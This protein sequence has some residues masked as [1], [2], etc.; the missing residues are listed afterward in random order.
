MMVY[1]HKEIFSALHLHE[2]MKAVSPFRLVVNFREFQIGKR[3]PSGL[4]D[5]R[6]Y[7]LGRSEPRCRRIGGLAQELF[8]SV[9]FALMKRGANA[10]LHPGR[11][12]ENLSLQF[13]SSDR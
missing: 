7:S 6:L 8:H 2:T 1:L 4:S 9:L 3:A 10:R 5:G 13:S 11:D 12:F